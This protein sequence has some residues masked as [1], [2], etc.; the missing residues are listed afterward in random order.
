VA[1]TNCSYSSHFGDQPT[2]PYRSAQS[3]LSNNEQS[4]GIDL[5]WAQVKAL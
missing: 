3:E 2:A 5:T 4:P 1:V